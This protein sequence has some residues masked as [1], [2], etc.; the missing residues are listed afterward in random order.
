MS[1]VEAVRAW[2]YDKAFVPSYYAMGRYPDEEATSE[3]KDHV[4]TCE[5]R[6]AS[7]PNLGTVDGFAG[8]FAG[9]EKVEGVVA[10]VGCGCD[11][12]ELGEE[13]TLFIPGEMS[14]SEVIAQVVG[15]S[16]DGDA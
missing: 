4:K 11:E 10:K 12:Y 8:T 14:L 2:F 3:F 9:D 16:G 1:Y 7:E 5:L 13:A 6:W 15:D